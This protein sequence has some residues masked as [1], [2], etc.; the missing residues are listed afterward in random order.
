MPTDTFFIQMIDSMFTYAEACNDEE[1]LNER[2]WL[3]EESKKRSITLYQLCFEIL[4]KYETNV[5]ARRW[6]HDRN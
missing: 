4:Y 3:D 1:L 5:K 6:L 2:K